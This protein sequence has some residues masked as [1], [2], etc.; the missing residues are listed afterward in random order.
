MC[1]IIRKKQHQ[2]TKTTVVHLHTSWRND[3][4]TKAATSVGWR[5]CRFS[6]YS[7]KQKVALS[8][9]ESC[10]GRIMT[11]ME[12]WAPVGPVL[13]VW[14]MIAALCTDPTWLQHFM[15]DFMC[16]QLLKVS[17]EL[18]AERENVIVVCQNVAGFKA[19]DG[20]YSRDE[21]HHTK[22]ENTWKSSV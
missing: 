1:K 17:W 16:A 15:C 21:P 7:H 20:K 18:T 19:S 22:A 11:Y 3:I 10:M 2:R 13:S 12:T 6:F 4:K 8:S 9:K 14:P 5:S